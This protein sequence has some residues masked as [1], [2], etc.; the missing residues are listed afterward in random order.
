M[1]SKSAAQSVVPSSPA[2]A[3]AHAIARLSDGF[4]HDT[5]NPLNAVVIHL[6]VLS[7][8]LKRE[9]AGAIP[10]GLE[11]NLKAIRDQVGRI[12]EMVRRFVELAAPHRQHEPEFDLGGLVDSVVAQ[13][14]HQARLAR[15][16]L[17][18][19]STPGLRVAGSAAELGVAMSLY[20]MGQVEGGAKRLLIRTESQGSR[21]LLIFEGT[22]AAEEG[23]IAPLERVA[24]TLS[25]SLNQTAGRTEL[26]LD[27]G[28]AAPALRVVS[29]GVE[30][31]Q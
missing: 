27:L 7:D 1:E 30:S 17:R 24:A 20:V 19:E 21:A 13:C 9:H 15:S 2:E 16:D 31:A 14:T 18:G 5:R 23:S 29:E 3:R 12:D 28:P 26:A 8:K 4:S 10:F 11:K 25:G 6:E 22:V